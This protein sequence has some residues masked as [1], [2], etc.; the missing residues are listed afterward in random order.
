MDGGNRQIEIEKAELRQQAALQQQEI[1]QADHAMEELQGKMLATGPQN[2]QP[3]NINQISL[4]DLVAALNNQRPLRENSERKL[5]LPAIEVPKFNGEYSQWRGWKNLYTTVVHNN[6]EY[7]S[8]EKFSH[9][10]SRIGRE[11][12]EIVKH[13]DLTE[14]NYHRAWAEICDRFNNERLLV[15]AELS[16]MFNAPP[17]RMVANEIKHSHDVFKR[18]QANL[19]SL[20]KEQDPDANA[21]QIA[22][23]LW[24]AFMTFLMESKMEKSV[25]KEL[26]GH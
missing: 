3:S 24:Q 8:I 5:K 19:E 18:C 21:D 12:S 20:M 14:D 9:L 1:Q 7:S 13:L 23:R 15:S 11:A 10:K 25:K 16:D 6:T 17:I 22:S 2:N 26:I 4:A